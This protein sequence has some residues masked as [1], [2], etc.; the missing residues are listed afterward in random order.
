MKLLKCKEI[1]I[2]DTV[3]AVSGYVKKISISGTDY[4]GEELRSILSLRS[5]NFTVE[6]KDGIY[7]FTCQGYGH[8]VGMS[9]YGADAMA[10]S[11][12]SCGEILLHYYQGTRIDKWENI[13]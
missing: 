3:T 6:H 12:S 5:G 7:K 1:S 8:G 9:Q 10:K 13:L 2:G 4:T 11:G